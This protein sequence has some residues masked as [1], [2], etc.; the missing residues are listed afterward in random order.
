MFCFQFSAQSLYSLY[1]WYWFHTIIHTM[2]I[3]HTFRVFFSVCLESFVCMFFTHNDWYQIH[4]YNWNVFCFLSFVFK[5]KRKKAELLST[6]YHY[7]QNEPNESRINTHKIVLFKSIWMFRSKCFWWRQREKKIQIKLPESMEYEIRA[8]SCYR[9]LKLPGSLNELSDLY[10][11]NNIF[12]GF[13]S[14]WFVTLFI[15]ACNNS[16]I[17]KPIYWK[18]S[19]K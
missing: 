17:S 18:S 8:N 3:P 1:T 5:L 15:D 7:A 4:E 9:K 11:W 10:F 12:K 13:I 2:Y 6:I 14:K 16:D 19:Y